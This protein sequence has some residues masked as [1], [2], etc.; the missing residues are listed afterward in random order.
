MK[1]QLSATVLAMA[2]S[3]SSAFV[4]PSSFGIA[5]ASSST[6]LSMVLEKPKKEKKLSKLEI[7][8]TKSDHLTNPLK[9]VSVKNNWRLW[10]RYDT[11]HYDSEILHYFRLIHD[12]VVGLS[13]GSL[14]LVLIRTKTTSSAASSRA[15]SQIIVN[16]WLG[17]WLT[18]CRPSW[19]PLIFGYFTMPRLNLE[20]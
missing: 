19:H 15:K 14:Y 17:A 11:T 16:Y 12:W 5:K 6:T 1:F 18:I 13:W 2:L 4:N 10:W 8:K 20:I 9:E 7:L 3:G